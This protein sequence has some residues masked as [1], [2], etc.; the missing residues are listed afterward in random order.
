[1][2]GLGRVLILLGVLLVVAGA[3]C[4]VG[5]RLG[6]GALPG[7]LA[8]RRGNVGVYAPLASCIVLSILLSVVLNILL[9]FLR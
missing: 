9:R 3:L 8:W 6:L 5:A 2:L 1:M 7:D 4:V